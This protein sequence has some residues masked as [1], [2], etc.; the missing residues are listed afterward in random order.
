METDRQSKQLRAKKRVEE[1]KGFYTHL[2]IFVG[3]NSMLILVKVVGTLYK[4]ETFMGPLWHFS[5]FV[6]PVLWGLGLAFHGTKVFG[7]VPFFGKRWE[8]RQL[9]KF[10]EEDQKEIEKYK[11]MDHGK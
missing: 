9:R 8:E 5:T 3:I 11:A 10:L 2:M 7:L 6:T 4:G 1:L